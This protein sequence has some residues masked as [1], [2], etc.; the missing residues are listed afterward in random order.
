MKKTKPHLK[1]LEKRSSPMIFVG[2][3]ARSKAYRMYNHVDGRVNIAR[4]AVFDE[5]A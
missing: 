2:Y 4:D 1:K 5:A 3:E